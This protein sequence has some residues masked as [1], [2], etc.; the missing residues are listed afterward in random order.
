MRYVFFPKRCCFC[1]KVIPPT[2]DAC[3]DCDECVQRIE[4]P[5]CYAC[6]C[7]RRHCICGEKHSPFVAAYAAPFY[8]ADGV[9]NGIHRMKFRHEPE[10]A[11]SYGREM[12]RFAREVYKDVKIDFVT[13]VPM[14]ETEKRERG[15]N[16]SELLAVETAAGL[17]LPMLPALEK[18]YETRRQRTLRERQRSGNVLGVFEADEKTVRGKRILLCDDLKTTGATLNECAKMLML[19]GAREVLCLTAAVKRPDPKKKG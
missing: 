16:Q 14:T 8:Y 12:A 9:R 6:G 1:G 10:L 5:I 13:F 3:T 2:A 18:L 17:T 7:S 4:P 15:Y 11:E 19:R